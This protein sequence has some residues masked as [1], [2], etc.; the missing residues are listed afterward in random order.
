MKYTDKLNIYEGHEILR[1]V[2]QFKQAN[3]HA[4]SRICGKGNAGH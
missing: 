2:N 1:G 3:K 4:A